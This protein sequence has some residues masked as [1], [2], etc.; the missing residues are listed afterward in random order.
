MIKEKPLCCMIKDA[1]SEQIE[2]VTELLKDNPGYIIHDQDY[3]FYY[4]SDE[5]A[6]DKR[7]VSLEECKYNLR[8]KYIH[9]ELTS[10]EYTEKMSRL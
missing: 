5:V 8:M 4:P 3:L 9:G 1:T 10:E 6:E 7:V 2:Y